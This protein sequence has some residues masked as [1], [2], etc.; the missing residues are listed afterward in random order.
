[1]S[2]MKAIEVQGDYVII[3]ANSGSVISMIDTLGLIA[4]EA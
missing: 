4:Y 2:R 3:L 1:M